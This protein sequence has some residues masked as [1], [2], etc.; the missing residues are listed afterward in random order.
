MIY[1]Q[2]ETSP[3][4]HSGRLHIDIPDSRLHAIQQI[5]TLISDYQKQF[6]DQNYLNILTCLMAMELTVP[7]NI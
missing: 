6:W 7:L 2:V 3:I 5:N 1:G 4:N